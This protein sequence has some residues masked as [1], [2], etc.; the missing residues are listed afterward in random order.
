M[1]TAEEHLRSTMPIEF[2]DRY[3]LR[4]CSEKD[5]PEVIDLF[6]GVWKRESFRVWLTDILRGRQPRCPLRYQCRRIL[7]TGWR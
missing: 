5:I 7:G 4:F 3:L 1:S 2:A 6:D